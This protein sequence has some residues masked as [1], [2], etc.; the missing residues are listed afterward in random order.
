VDA[1]SR[2]LPGVLVGRSI[3][4]MGIVLEV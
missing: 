3:S 4:A 2:M 1:R